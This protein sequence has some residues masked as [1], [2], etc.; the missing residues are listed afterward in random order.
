MTPLPI[1]DEIQRIDL[2]AIGLIAQEGK[3]KRREIVARFPLADWP[4]LPLERYALGQ[5]NTDTFCWWLEYGS[6]DLGRITG[7][8]AYKMMVYKRKNEP[9][10]FFPPEYRDEHA[11]W[12]A[13]RGLFVRVFD[14]A[15]KNNWPL[16]DQL[17]PQ[18]TLG[19]VVMRK[20]L[21]VYFPNQILSIYSRAWLLFYAN[22]LGI[23]NARALAETR[24]GLNRAVLAA[25]RQIPALAELSPLEIGHALV[26]WQRP[27]A[28][29]DIGDTQEAQE[30]TE[31]AS[32]P[33]RYMH[34]AAGEKGRLWREW[35]NDGVATI[36]WNDL[37]DLSGITSNADWERVRV[38]SA[39]RNADWGSG[40]PWMVWKFRNLRPGD[41]LIAR[42]GSDY[43][44]DVGQVTGAYF[45]DASKEHAHRIPVR[46]LGQEGRTVSHNFG[47]QTLREVD[48]DRF[49]ALTGM[50]PAYPAPAADA[51]TR[52]DVHEHKSGL[53]STPVMSAPQ[54]PSLLAHVRRYTASRGYYFD[55]ETI[56]NYHI[57]LKTR[58]F[59]IL[60]GLSGTGKSKLTQLY[61]EAL[62]C[63]SGDA[64]LRLAVQP[65]WTE[66]RYLLGYLDLNGKWRSE[67][68]LRFLLQ[69]NRNRNALHFCCLDE[70]NLARVEYYFASMLSAMEE[71]REDQR[72]VTL[73]GEDT[74]DVEQSVPARVKLTD[75][76]AFTGT[77]NIDETTQNLSD[78]V[79]DRA[80]IIEL[81]TVAFDKLP[82]PGGVSPGAPVA[83]LVVSSAAWRGYRA[84]APD[85]SRRAQL[86][87]LN[88]LLGRMRLG[89]GYRVL[90]E[91]E[92]YLANSAGLLP[93]ETAFDLQVRQRILPRVRGDH[94]IEDGL[95]AL[96]EFCEH[97]ALPGSLEKVREMLERLKQDGYT[98]FF[99]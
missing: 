85:Q 31:V 26:Q 37:G 18:L 29:Q 38:A 80:N 42:R 88:K 45:F 68:L 77:I 63:A 75:N 53:A 72:T 59:V 83:P 78:K 89:V 23:D 91:V 28:A 35:Q 14:A 95:S 40:G 15:S 57:A 79:L 9:G 19:R 30:M 32:I 81:N 82:E 3:A 66:E 49:A 2:R 87:E 62:G 46:W 69:A 4:T 55:D 84:Q 60:A 16:V 17:Q 1:H 44:I 13:V 50:S 90:R 33:P 20:A 61:A 47:V 41:W 22:A 74:T 52:T 36:G 76:L 99:R 86:S 65:N 34:I 39:E 54:E 8:S 48:A 7:G 73:Y 51:P 5:G 25:A 92:W 97:N 6:D 67:K 58:P 10:W 71:D 27:S 64:Y 21:H 98:S 56:A 43:L 12:D 24:S 70:M 93:L 11:A 94:H 96:R